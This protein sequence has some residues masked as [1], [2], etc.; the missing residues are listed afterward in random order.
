V[1]R[2][3]SR[4]GMCLA[5]IVAFA[6]WS[7]NALAAGDVVISQVYGGGGNSGATYTND[8]IELTNRTGVDIDL[9]AWSVQYAAST[10]TNWSRTNLVGSIPAGGTYLIQESAG[11]GG[12][13]PLPS[14]RVTGTIAMAAGAGK[15]VLVA[16]QTTIASGTVCPAVAVDIVGYGSSTTCS[17]SAPTPTLS[18]TTAAIRKGSGTE[19]TDSNGADFV[20]GAPSPHGT[21]AGGG[22]G[23]LTGTPLKIDQ[24]QGSGQ[25]SPQEGETVQTTGVVTALR[26]TGTARGFWLQD[27]APDGD[28][29]TS[30]GIFVFTASTTPPVTVGDGVA[31]SGTVKE[32]ASAGD[33]PETEL[34]SPRIVRR[35]SGNPLPT[36]IVIGLGGQQPPTS[37]IVDGIAFDERFEGML[38]QLNDIQAVSPV[39]SF[40]E[41]Y[42]VPDNGAGASVLTPRGGLLLQADDDN[43]EKFRV[44]DDIFGAPEGSMAKEDVGA[45]AA[46]PQVGVMDY[47]FS[48]YTIH[49]LHRPVWTPSTN[50]RETTTITGGDDVLTVATFNVEN[51]APQDPASK[52]A[53]LAD[54]L[55]NRLRA[56]DVVALEE[57][58]DNS[59]G[60]DDGVVDS[61]QTLDKLR[62]A[63]VA[64]GGPV[65]DYRW[66][67]PAN[68]QDGGQPGGNIRVVFFFRTDVPGLLFAPGDP[69]DSTSSEQVVGSG[70]D[71]TLRYNPGRIDPTS[72]AW[73]SSRKPLV[74][75][76]VF[77]GH[78]VFVVANHFNSKLGDDPAWGAQQPPVRGSEVQRHEQ[79]TEVKDFVSTLF[80]ANANANVIVL[81]DLNDFQFSDTL[82]ILEQAGL[83]ALIDDLPLAERYSY[84]FEGNSQAIDHML[85][86]GGLLSRPRAY[87]PVHVNAEFATQVSDHDPQVGGFTL[88]GPI[89][90]ANGPY[91][92][93][94][95]STAKLVASGSDPSGGALSYRWD[96]DGDGVYETAGASPAFSAADGPATRTVAVR[97]TA[98]DGAIATSSALV[99]VQNVAPSAV[100]TAPAALNAPAAIVLGLS[101]ATDPSAADTAAGFEFAFDCGDGLGAW[102]TASTTSCPTSDVGTRTVRGAIRDRDGGVTTYTATVDVSVTVD[103]LCA[104]VKEWAKNAGETTSLCVKLQNGQIDAFA[105]ELDAQAG[106]AFTVEQAA[107]LKLLAARL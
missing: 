9:T 90:T 55:V 39:N 88:D 107:L 28:I 103:S 20:V 31:V 72:S 22:D 83:H 71:T 27:T 26:S 61:R 68:D 2:A 40:G 16:S 106:K 11:T 77:N 95:G 102:S 25:V 17:E 35:S 19:D 50:E 79:A 69:G 4:L 23:G 44:D 33:L 100:F 49:L 51:L 80:A 67:D 54:V 52:Y 32:F 85:A 53:G 56:P 43:P 48:D 75:H 34:T 7:G 10:G 60:A 89:V 13:T 87:D 70:A 62:D 65:Y 99:Q 41:V 6:V 59:G 45:R 93:D 104:T 74:G 36:P 24:I 96:L 46:G 18:N 97:A 105:H 81:G 73:T 94:E 64:A 86:G 3:L 5:L 12:T 15:V 42:V 84:V 58:Q 63:V 101:G 78:S 8:F 47:A 82:S 57:V 30:E 37:S 66:I 92:V 29:S 76:F 14:P 91:T 98:P 21:P 1:K 38:V